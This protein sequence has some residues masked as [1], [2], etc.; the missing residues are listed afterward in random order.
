L[1][2]ERFTSRRKLMSKVSNRV[3]GLISRESIP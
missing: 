2:V 3:I 1:M